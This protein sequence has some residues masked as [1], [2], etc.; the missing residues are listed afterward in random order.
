MNSKRDQLAKEYQRDEN[1]EK[2]GPAN[3][4]KAG[5]DACE[6]NAME[7]S[8]K[9]DRQAAIDQ[10][11]HEDSDIYFRFISGAEWQHQQ[12]AIKISALKRRIEELERK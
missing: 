10:A 12:S 3:S 2:L 8:D 6:K 5:W 11:K 1:R 4:F 7:E 9:F